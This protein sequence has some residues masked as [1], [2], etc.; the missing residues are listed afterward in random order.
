MPIDFLTNKAVVCYEVT[1]YNVCNERSKI[2]YFRYKR[3]KQVKMDN[4]E[5]D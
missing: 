3:T 1:Y 2:N 4:G 5:I